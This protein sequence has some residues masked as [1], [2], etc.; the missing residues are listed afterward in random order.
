[1]T[2]TTLTPHLVVSDGEAAVAFYAKAFGATLQ[3][4]NVAD[5]G[6]RLLHAHMKL[7]AGDL[8]LH[9]DFPEHGGKG[10]KSPSR[11]GGAS[12]TLHIEVPDA[13]AAWE[14]AV[15]AG[16]AELMPLGNQFWGLPPRSGGRWKTRP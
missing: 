3:A 14:Q 1:M 4:K 10:A 2:A 8:L 7:G 15:K 16:A 13:D 11:L 5:D 6:K 12:C 9:D